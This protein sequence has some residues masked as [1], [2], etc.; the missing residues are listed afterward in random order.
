MQM[1]SFS[2]ASGDSLKS[3]YASIRNIGLL[4]PEEEHSL[5]LQIAKGDK[6]ARKR[7]VEANLRLVI[8]IAH[9]FHS[10]EMSMIDLVQE[11]NIG[12]IKAAERF[13]GN[14]NIRFSTYAAW[15]IRQSIMRALVNTGRTIR[16][17]HRKEELLKHM[18]ASIGTLSQR[19]KRSPTTSELAEELDVVPA[20]LTELIAIAAGPATLENDEDDEGGI[21]DVYEDYSYSPEREYEK[22]AVREETLLLLQTLQEKEKMVLAARFELFGQERRTLKQVGAELGLSPETVRQVEKRAVAKLRAFATEPD[23]AQAMAS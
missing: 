19:F 1:N 16:L 17:P 2:D 9:G 12:L 6:A 22:T 8:K 5:A 4:T 23:C 10:T 20:E 11:G 7:L 15:W 3:Y 13:D 21:L 14:R 18:Q